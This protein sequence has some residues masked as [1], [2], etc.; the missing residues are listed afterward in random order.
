MWP[1]VAQH[2]ANTCQFFI[3]SNMDSYAYYNILQETVGYFF[4]LE[5]RALLCRKC[6]VA[7][8]TANSFVSAHRRFLLTGVRVDLDATEAHLSS[9][10]GKTHTAEKMSELENSSLSKRTN[11]VSSTNH[12]SKSVPVQASVR[13]D[14]PSSKLPLAGGYSTGSISQWQLD[15]FID[16]THNYNFIDIGSSKVLIMGLDFRFFRTFLQFLYELVKT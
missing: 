12:S 1:S 13:G 4:C 9:S 14:V 8:H 7:I 16:F 3:Y 11:Q 10:L 2:L 6:D 15:E 5:D